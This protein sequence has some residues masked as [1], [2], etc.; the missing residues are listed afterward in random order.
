MSYKDVISMV[1]IFAD[2][3]DEQIA[4]I[5]SV[6]KILMFRKDEIIFEE[7][8]PSKEFYIIVKG[9]V[10]IQLDP[11]LIA[12]GGDSHKPH[13][14]GT[15]QHGQSFGEIALVDEGARSATVKSNE[16]NCKLLLI[17]RGD[18]M[19]L[20]DEDREMGFVVMQNLAVDLCFKI[21][22]TNMKIREAPINL[23]KLLQT[24]SW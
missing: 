12:S 6:C 3:T 16:E 11:N 5:E 21:R 10:D 8:S 9:S 2:L 19:R 13:T 24:L 15:L 18:F 1:N 23:N 17:T 4:K 14:I 22:N 7:R 20:L